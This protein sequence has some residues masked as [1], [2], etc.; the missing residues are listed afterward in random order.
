MVDMDYVVGIG[1]ALWDMLP[2]GKQLGGAP[3]NFAYH[4]RQFGL[5][6]LAV[7]AVGRDKLGDEICYTLSAKDLP[8]HME[9]VGQPTGT[10]QVTLDGKGV[11]QYEI[12]TDVAWDNLHFDG[13]LLRIASR[14]RAVCF[15]T[16]AQRSPVSR[17][18]VGAFL[19]AVPRDCIKVFDINLRQDFYSKYIVSRS[20]CR[21][22]ILKIN[23]EELAVLC[24]M[25]AFPGG[26]PLVVCPYI[27]K[28]YRLEM[29]ILTCGTSCSYVFY[30]GAVS[31]LPTP[32][33]KVADTVGAGDAFTG[34]FVAS[35]LRGEDVAAAHR[36]AVEVSAYVCTCEGAMPP[37][38]E[39]VLHI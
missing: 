33:V 34:A 1:E 30:D 20:L 28:R 10:V 39:D 35:L 37:L 16:L 25:Y 36:R 31:F 2:G 9:R 19:D 17:R 24:S 11:P 22:N 7:S 18:S 32:V 8:F 4:V 26:D 6:G 5:E 21:S 27:L 3:A 14:T 38:P 13:E 12:K 15:G 23:D 29:L